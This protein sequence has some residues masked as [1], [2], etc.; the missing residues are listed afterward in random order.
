MALKNVISDRVFPKGLGGAVKCPEVT[1][2]SSICHSYKAKQ[3][4]RKE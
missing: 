4:T 3:T 1:D 2:F